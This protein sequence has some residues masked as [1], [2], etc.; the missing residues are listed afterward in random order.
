LHRLAPREILCL[1]FSHHV[2]F[3]GSRTAPL[4]AEGKTKFNFGHGAIFLNLSRQ[5]WRAS[6]ASE[7]EPYQ[8]KIVFKKGLEEI[9]PMSKAGPVE[10][11][12]LFWGQALIILREIL[13]KKRSLN[14]DKFL[15]AREIFLEDHE[16]W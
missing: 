15:S 16:H 9:A 8:F 7:I 11:L 4:D 1:T 10:L 2:R 12:Q 6:H 5:P 3:A 14:I 13:L